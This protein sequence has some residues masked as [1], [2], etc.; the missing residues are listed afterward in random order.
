MI[1]K[2][3]KLEFQSSRQDRK[4]NSFVRF[5]GEVMARQCC[6]EIYWPL[7]ETI[8]RRHIHFEIQKSAN[9]IWSQD[10][11]FCWNLAKKITVTR[12]L[13]SGQIS[14]IKHRNL[15]IGKILH[16]ICIIWKFIVK[17]SVCHGTCV[18]RIF[19][20]GMQ[21]KKDSECKRFMEIFDMFL[22]EL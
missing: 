16:L 2:H 3:L 9:R 5:L 8:V 17:L 22:K 4:T 19:S 11:S 13:D 15:G 7:V 20:W 6:F 18:C 1:P 14:L 10:F 21:D 12:K